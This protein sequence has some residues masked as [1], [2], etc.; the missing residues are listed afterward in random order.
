MCD[1]LFVYV[2]SIGI[3]Q[4][5]GEKSQSMGQ[6]EFRAVIKFLTKQRKTTQANLEDMLAACGACYS[7]KTMVYKCHSLFK[8]TR[9]IEYDPCS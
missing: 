4:F 9:K 8:H 6:I 2:P 3:I 1:S 5:K 7:G